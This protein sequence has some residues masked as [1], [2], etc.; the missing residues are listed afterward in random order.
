MVTAHHDR[1]VG[2]LSIIS[3]FCQ[4]AILLWGSGGSVLMFNEN[5]I[6]TGL[7]REIRRRHVVPKLVLHA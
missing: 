1:R 2:E 7:R 3:R 4:I 5:E 6:L